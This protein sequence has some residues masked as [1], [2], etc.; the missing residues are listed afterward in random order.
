MSSGTDQAPLFFLEPTAEVKLDRDYVSRFPDDSPERRPEFPKVVVEAESC[1]FFGI[2]RISTI[3]FSC[4]NTDIICVFLCLCEPRGGKSLAS[5]IRFLFFE[6]IIPEDGL[7][8]VKGS[9]IGNSI[10]P[11]SSVRDICECECSRPKNRRLA[12]SFRAREI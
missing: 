12:P 10:C 2:G 1:V 9:S 8:K 7:S 3:R 5:E 6:N 11:D 4:G